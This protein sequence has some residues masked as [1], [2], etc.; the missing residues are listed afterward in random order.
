MVD[1]GTDYNEKE[2]KRHKTAIQTNQTWKQLEGSQETAVPAGEKEVRSITQ[3][4]RD[5]FMEAILQHYHD[6]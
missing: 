1:R 2:N 4:Y 6:V 5:A 3:E